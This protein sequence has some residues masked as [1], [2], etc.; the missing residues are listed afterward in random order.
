MKI[1][2]S[3]LAAKLFKAQ[4]AVVF[5]TDELNKDGETVYATA[6]FIGHF[7]AVPVS[8]A[9]ADMDK[10]KELR[11]SGDH[12]GMIGV[13]AKRLEQCFVGFEPLPG[14]DFP[15]TDDNDQPLANTPENIKVL[16][17]SREVRD[18]VRKTF[19]AARS[20]DVL[21]KNLQK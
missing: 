19:E 12:V 20:A 9:Q 13:E 14:Q 17:N 21:E 8:D 3:A 7:R 6:R 2:A 11:N 4:V 18:A 16:L 15:V 5:P 1:K 10:L